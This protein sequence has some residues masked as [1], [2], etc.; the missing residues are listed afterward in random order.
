MKFGDRLVDDLPVC[1]CGEVVAVPHTECK[2]I[3]P[4]YF[5]RERDEEVS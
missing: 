1:S 2:A 5:E 4:R 3:N